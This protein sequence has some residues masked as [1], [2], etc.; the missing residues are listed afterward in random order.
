[1]PTATITGF[2]TVHRGAE[3]LSGVV[4]I[5]AGPNGQI[6]MDHLRQLLTHYRGR[7]AGIMIMNS[8]TA[9]GAP[10][11]VA[12]VGG[13]PTARQQSSRAKSDN[14]YRTSHLVKGLLASGGGNIASGEDSSIRRR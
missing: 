8:N 11:Y 13:G 9:P 7:I 2:E 1:M 14:T 6:D 10:G 4:E 12:H 3:T 5:N